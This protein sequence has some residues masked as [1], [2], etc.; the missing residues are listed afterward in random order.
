MNLIQPCETIDYKFTEDDKNML[1]DGTLEL[2]RASRLTRENLVGEIDVQ[3]KGTLKKLRLKSSGYAK[4]PV[5]VLDLKK[6]QEV[7]HGVLF[8]CV[9]VDSSC[10]YA[11]GKKVFYAQLLPYDINRI[12]ADTKPDQKTV[13]VRFR[14]FPVEPREIVRL[15]SAFHANQEKQRLSTVSGYGFLDNNQE[16]PS[17]I[18]SFSF[19][20]RLFP[21]EDITTLAAFRNGAY[22]YGED[23]HGQSLVFGKVEDVCMFAMGREA[24]VESGGFSFTTLVFAGEHEDGRYLEFEGVILIISERDVKFNY[25]VSGEFHRRYNTVR[26]AKEFIRTGVLSLNGAVVLRVGMDAVDSTQLQRLEDS[27]KVYAPIVETLDAIGITAKWD[28][29]EMSDKELDD[30]GFMHQLLVKRE[31]LKGQKLESPLVHFDIQDCRVYAFA[32]E[33]E[34]GSYE[35]IDLQSDELFFVFGWPN[36]KAVNEGIGFD[37]VPPI[38]AI[39]EEGYKRIVNLVPNRLSEAFGRFP[40]TAGNQEPLNQKLLEMLAAYDL[41]CQQ[42]DALLACAAIVA[43]KL[44]EFAPE[45]DTYYLNLMQTFKRKRALQGDETKRLRNLAIDSESPYVKAAAYALLDDGVMAETCLQRCTE[46]EKKQIADYPIATFFKLN[47]VS[48]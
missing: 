3:I 42:P 48:L 16:L 15:T 45:S 47:Q 14:P 7:Y 37:P 4:H 29:A 25:T 32:K 39:G 33:C 20:T 1:V 10:G 46:D 6:Y 26:F 27:I 22:I 2:Y 5:S 38:V 21:G 34:D 35:F 19:S 36:D 17:N 28:P 40:V 18:K 13:N 8:F 31:P 24:T 11:T 12:L 41:G 43:R 44:H 23:D 9:L 30:I